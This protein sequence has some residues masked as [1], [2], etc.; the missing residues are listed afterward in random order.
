M[1]REQVE[2]LAE[3]QRNDPN[4]IPRKKRQPGITNR[5]VAGSPNWQVLHEWAGPN[6]IVLTRTRNEAY[7]FVSKQ[8]SRLGGIY[9][10]R[11]WYMGEWHHDSYCI[12]EN[13]A[14]PTK[15]LGA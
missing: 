5:H 15:R 14:Y 6:R 10:I 12:P 7:Q 4:Y 13:N 11:E 9:S 1:T 3:A 2:A 8:K